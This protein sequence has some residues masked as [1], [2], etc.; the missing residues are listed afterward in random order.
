MKSSQSNTWAESKKLSKLAGPIIIGQVG[1][2]LIM[3]ADT[4]MLGAVGAIALGASAFSSSVYIIFF[5]FGLGVLAPLTALYAKFQGQGQHQEAGRLLKHSHVLAALI[6]SITSLILYA[7]LF[8]LD[9]FGQTKEINN[10][11]YGFFEVMIWGVFPALFYQSYK[12]FAD[13][14]GRTHAGMYTM[15]FGVLLNVGLNYLLIFGKHGFPELGIMGAAYATLTARWTMAILMALYVH[16][17]PHFKSY[18]RE[19]FKMPY[20]SSILKDLTKLGIP[21][22]F[23]L[24][25]EVGAFAS[26]SIIMGW[27]GSLP[28]AAH[29]I[30]LS[31]A[32]TSFL[33]TLGIGI[34]ASIRVGYEVGAGNPKQARF[35]GFNAIRIGTAYMFFCA[36]GFYFFR[37]WLPTL[38]VDDVDVIALTASFFIVVA[39]FEIFDG[40]QAIAIGAL[41]GLADTKVPSIIAFIAYWVLGIPVGFYLAFYGGMGPI[42]IWVGLLLGLV[43]ASV[44]LTYRFHTMTR[45]HL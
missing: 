23:T 17:S 7:V 18:L 32:S 31:L 6:G 16:L 21:T 38:Y 45:K 40:I 5:I 33:V 35:A 9:S 41:R 19:G 22:G 37:E 26:C 44:L 1:Q 13:G 20:A 15:L 28:L 29:Q 24:F 14:I 36:L 30:A 12:Q 10:A 27:F 4:I 8:N 2:N 42:G 39:L 34:A 11:A 3:L 25:F 43:I